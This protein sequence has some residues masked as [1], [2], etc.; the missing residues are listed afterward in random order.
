[1][2]LG[3]EAKKLINLY[4]KSFHEEALSAKLGY[5]LLLDWMAGKWDKKTLMYY[6]FCKVIL[7]QCSLYVKTP[8]NNIAQNHIQSRMACRAPDLVRL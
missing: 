6:E 3:G 4:P 1:M 8:S 5:F 2:C 7:I